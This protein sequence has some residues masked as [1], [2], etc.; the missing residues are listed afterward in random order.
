MKYVDLQADNLTFRPVGWRYPFSARSLSAIIALS[1]GILIFGASFAAETLQARELA[2]A[3]IGRGF[4]VAAGTCALLIPLLHMRQLYDLEALL[5]L[6]RQIAQTLFGW[7]A[8]LCF[9]S[10]LVFALKV[11]STFSRVAVSY[12][13][14]GGG[15]AL[16]AH[17][18][19][20]R[21]IIRRAFERGALKGP[22][23]ALIEC[24]VA[25]AASTRAEMRRF[26]LNIARRFDVPAD[27]TPS[28]LAQVA[29]TALAEIHGS[30]IDEIYIAADCFSLRHARPL[31]GFLSAAPLPVRLVLNEKTTELFTNN[32]QRIG[33]LSS[34]EIRRPPLSW[35]ERAAK[36]IIDVAV[37][38]IAILI[39]LPLL[40]ITALAVKLDSAGP[41][42]FL[43]KRKGFNGRAFKI[44]KFRS[45][46]VLEDG[47]KIVQAQRNDDRVTRIGRFLRKTSIDELPQLIN[48][49]IGDMSLIGPRPHAISHDEY[50]S[51]ELADYAFRQHV[52]PGITGWAQIHGFRGET[53]TVDLMQQRIQ[54]DIWYINHWSLWLDISIMFRTVFE[55]V[56]T[57]NAF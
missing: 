12:Y 26:G 49:L 23:I 32:Q 2:S 20:V 24:S 53:A 36:R 41:V 11:G 9:L 4:A 22:R 18:V 57:R 56:R 3:D 45:M 5:A 6:R 31:L 55:V 30:D 48:V 14:L 17:R 25:A 27:P 34:F 43:Q 13:L 16:V 10:A 1:D 47:A 44:F 38:S 33:K 19:W 46:I 8:T 28:H 21:A 15:L 7:I 40:V 37:A 51:T 50:Y 54:H 42:F 29:E 52:K 39:L 35:Q